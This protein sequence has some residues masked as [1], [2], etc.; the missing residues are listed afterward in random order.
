[1][2][3]CFRPFLGWLRLEVPSEES[4]R[5]AHRQDE[6]LLREYWEGQ[7][8]HD[9]PGGRG[10]IDDRG[11]SAGGRLSG[12]SSGYLGVVHRRLAGLAAEPA[13]PAGTNNLFRPDPRYIL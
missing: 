7:A 1:M 5:K 8:Q 10:P 2:A 13:N 3:D 9:S 4:I 6:K 11:R 12:G